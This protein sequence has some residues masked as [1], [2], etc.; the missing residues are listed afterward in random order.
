MQPKKTQIETQKSKGANPYVCSYSTTG[1]V[2]S[3]RVPGGI[4]SFFGIEGFCRRGVAGV[5]EIGSE[6]SSSILRVWD[7]GE[8]ESPLLRRWAVP[9]LLRMDA[10]LDIV[11]KRGRDIMGEEATRQELT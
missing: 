11:R 6:S 5:G 2:I 1:V 4:R 8:P 7:H 10:S 9:P 3:V